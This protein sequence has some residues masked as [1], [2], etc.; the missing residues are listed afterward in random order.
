MRMHSVAAID[1]RMRLMAAQFVA[2]SGELRTELELWRSTAS[3]IWRLIYSVSAY[4]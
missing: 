1:G 4:S 3:D 2:L